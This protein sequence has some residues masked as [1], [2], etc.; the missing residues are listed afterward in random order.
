[1]TKDTEAETGIAQLYSRQKQWWDIFS[2][3]HRPQAGNWPQP[4]SFP[5]CTG[6][7]YRGGKGTEAWSWPITSIYCQGYECVEPYLLS[8][9]VFMAWCL[10]QHGDNITFT[11]TFK[12]TAVSLKY[13]H[14]NNK[15]ELYSQH[16]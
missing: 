10:V 3:R 7:S 11:F 6:D 9:N 4:H 15:T 12:G 5:I 13:S 1:M 8:P 16:Y 2:L 14:T